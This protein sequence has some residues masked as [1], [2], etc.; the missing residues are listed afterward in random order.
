MANDFTAYRV[1]LCSKNERSKG[2]LVQDLERGREWINAS[3]SH[4]HANVLEGERVGIL[5]IRCIFPRTEEKEEC[6]PQ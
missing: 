5:G 3:L 4:P 6:N 2:H 1:L